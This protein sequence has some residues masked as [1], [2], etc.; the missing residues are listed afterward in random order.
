MKWRTIASKRILSNRFLNVEK[1]AVELPNGVSIDDYYTV[2]FPEAAAVV[3]VTE[4]GK[5]VLKS[6]YRYACREDLIEIPAGGVDPGEKPIDAARRELLEETGYVSEK[7]QH[8]VSS[9]ECTSKLTNIM[10]IFLALDCKKVA[11]QHLDPTE[12]LDVIVVP[13]QEA[14]DMILNGKIKCCSSA[15]GILM[16]QQLLAAQPDQ[17]CPQAI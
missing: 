2:T 15:H 3:A 4:D 11:A 12:N 1:N 9:R 5:I 16:T 17:L 14:V 8:L 7:W 13:F 6:E 10:H